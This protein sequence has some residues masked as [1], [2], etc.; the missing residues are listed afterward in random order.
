MIQFIRNLRTNHPGYV[1]A[2]IAILVALSL[3]TAVINGGG[4]VQ[5]WITTKQTVKD[6]LDWSK[7]TYASTRIELERD[8]RVT[9]RGHRDHSPFVAF[10]PERGLIYQPLLGVT[11][12]IFQPRP[13]RKD[14]FGYRNYQDHY[15]K[16]LAD[17]YV[18]FF[19]DS[20]A[21]GFGHDKPISECLEE[22]LNRETGESWAVVN[23]AVNGQSIPYQINAYTTLF[24]D[25]RP[26][27]VISHS[28]VVD[29]NVASRQL[30]EFRAL[31]YHF[32]DVE[33]DWAR[34]VH[35]EQHRFD[36]AFEWK[37]FDGDGTAELK[38]FIK[39]LRK[40]RSIVENNG[41][42][43]L[44]GLQIFREGHLPQQNTIV[45]SAY[46]NLKADPGLLEG[47]DTF[48][49]NTVEGLNL[50][51]DDP[52]HTDQQSAYRIAEIYAERILSRQMSPPRPNA[53]K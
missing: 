17:R 37:E 48:D 6:F 41:G 14:Y 43:F 40:F 30:S 50:L 51:P 25:R 2:L 7:M 24:Y 9:E 26:D 36:R 28:F 42:H 3:E 32:M 4:Q 35:S 23:L 39:N 8:Q 46:A 22:I 53:A 12:A 29:I 38:G 27:F 44:H 10:A 19:G 11:G 34:L 5:L 18:L 1:E 49:F 16:P 20:E 13:G 15:F 52:I 31:G 33:V 21:V 47:I 45:Q